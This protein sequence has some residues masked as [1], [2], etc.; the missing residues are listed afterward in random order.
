[1]NIVS[2]VANDEHC[3]VVDENGQ[4]RLLTKRINGGSF[5]DLLEMENRSIILNKKIQGI[6][7]K[8][9]MLYKKNIVPFLLSIVFLLSLISPFIFDVS[10]GLM[11]KIALIIS[12]IS[13]I[14]VSISNTIEYIKYGKEY[15][16]FEKQKKDIDKKIRKILD[17]SLIV[18]RILFSR[19]ETVKGNESEEK[20]VNEC[21]DYLH[22]IIENNIGKID[23]F[24]YEYYNNPYVSS[25]K[26]KVLLPIS[27]E[28]REKT[29][30]IANEV[31]N[32]HDIF[33]IRSYK[34]SQLDDIEE[35]KKKQLK[36]TYRL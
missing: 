29:R 7:N 4:I 24:Y 14:T 35:G 11:S 23:T 26:I 18:E 13:S 3:G 36:K 31:G 16:K 21:A 30:E 22:R 6:I 27:E 5:K 2:I 17:K 32:S 10:L 25:D 12:F 1:M 15:T 28:D 8:K 9:E 34:Y 20:L 33:Q 19:D